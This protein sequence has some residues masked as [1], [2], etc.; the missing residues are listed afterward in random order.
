MEINAHVCEEHID[1]HCHCKLCGA[2]CH[3][4]RN[5]DVGTFAAPGKICATQC[6]RCCKSKLFYSDSGSVLESGFE[7][8]R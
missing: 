5:D 4:Y 2:I 8:E 1:S 6:V 7:N 3:D